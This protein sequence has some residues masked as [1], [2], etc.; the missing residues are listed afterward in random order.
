MDG[1]PPIIDNRE[2][3]TSLVFGAIRQTSPIPR[4]EIAKST[5]LSPATVTSIT[6]DLIARGI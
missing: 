3:G 5:G 2:T 1:D 6:A 4:I